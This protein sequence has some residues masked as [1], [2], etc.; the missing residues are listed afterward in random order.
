MSANHHGLS[1]GARKIPWDCDKFYEYTK[2]TEFKMQRSRMN[3]VT[4]WSSLGDRAGAR[5]WS[6]AQWRRVVY[7]SGMRRNTAAVLRHM[8]RRAVISTE[9]CA[10]PRNTAIFKVTA[11]VPS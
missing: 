3:L 1:F 4:Q 5:S 9:V 7:C 10:L 6:G 8:L 11:P 2:I